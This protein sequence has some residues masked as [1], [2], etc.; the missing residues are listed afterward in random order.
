MEK[1]NRMDAWVGQFITADGAQVSLE[2]EFSLAEMFSGQR[3]EQTPV[4]QRL[5]PPVIFEKHF[6]LTTLPQAASLKSTALGIYQVTLNDQPVTSALFAPDYTAY[7]DILQYQTYDVKK[8]LRVGDNVL[9]F[10]VADGWYAGRI[11]VQGGSAQF[12]DTLAVLADLSLTAEDGTQQVI[13]TDESFTASTGKWRYADI[14]IGEQ[15]DLRFSKPVQPTLKTRVYPTDYTRL[16]AQ[17]GPQVRR[18]ATIKA[19]RIWQEGAAQIIDFGQVLVGRVRLKIYLANGQKLTLDHSESLDQNG[20]FFQ[21]IVGRN[22]DQHDEFIGRG[23]VD[24][25]EPDFTFH[26]FRYVKVTGATELN[27][28]DIVAIVLFSDMPRTGHIQT[29]DSRINRLLENIRWSQQGN[30]LSIPTDCPQRERVGWTGDMQV[31]APASTFYYD[32]SALIRRWLASVRADQQANGEILDYSPAP[33]DFFKSIDFTGSLSSAGW[34]DAIIMVPW[35]LY[36]RFGDVTVLQENY[37]AMLRWHEYTVTSAAGDKTDDRRFLWDTKFNYGDW[38]LPSIM[39]ATHGNPMA[40]SEATRA[41]VGTAFLAHTTDLLAKIATILHEDSQPFAAYAQNVRAAFAKYYLRNGRLE[42]ELQGPYV[43][44]LAFNLVPEAQVNEAVDRLVTL[45][46]QN[47]NRLD[48]GFLSV[49]Y[50]LDV[51]VDHGQADLARTLF[52]QDQCPSW[53][54]EVDQGATTIWETWAGIAPDGT[55]GQFSFNHYAMGCVLDWFI[56]DV[57]GLNAAAPGFKAI[58]IAPKVAIV[59]DFTVA[60]DSPQGKIAIKLHDGQLTASVPAGVSAEFQLP[61]QDPIA[62]TGTQTITLGA[63]WN[64]GQMEE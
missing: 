33:K 2:P 35:T 60:F 22:K 23:Q 56:R 47:H 43:L 18:M 19:Q 7:H 36:Q 63:E 27:S 57:V 9:R 38:M 25:L 5:H 45:I 32:T 51:L 3:H 46:K 55:V 62:F 59:A 10:V 54:Y 37:Q 30:M 14:Q 58:T 29:S 16:R 26:G 61:S 64:L 48:T 8:Q 15:Q 11:S 17:M 44:A 34:G 24:V 13:G 31:F 20:H 42:R 41:V 4:N 50:L 6:N 39:A 12:G 40:T 52:T 1:R 28:D 49:P 21:N 53:L